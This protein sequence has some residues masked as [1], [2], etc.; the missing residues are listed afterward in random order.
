MGNDHSRKPLLP[1]FKHLEE[2]SI[3]ELQAVYTRYRYKFKSPPFLTRQQYSAIFFDE[4]K[5]KPAIDPNETENEAS[6]RKHKERIQK[7]SMRKQKTDPLA[8]LQFAYLDRF[9][10]QRIS[11]IDIF[12]GLSLIC[13][14]SMD[15][16]LKFAFSLVDFGRLN[17]INHA[18]LTLMISAA[19]RG[20]ARF[21]GIKD[22]PMYEADTIARRVFLQSEVNLRAGEGVG[23]YKEGGVTL[24]HVVA[25]CRKDVKQGPCS[26]ILMPG[27]I[28]LVY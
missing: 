25:F 23:D 5:P 27:H 11:A 2:V 14:E 1:I 22:A 6:I 19:L 18:E 12:A 28:F 8:D 13:H 21:K 7:I 17:K 26:I 4:D 24:K 3:E 10:R 16:R 15:G 20:I 9:K